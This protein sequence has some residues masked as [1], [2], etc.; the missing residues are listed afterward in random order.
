MILN[1]KSIINF[2][3]TFTN[4]K[5]STIIINEIGINQG[6]YNIKENLQVA[7]ACSCNLEIFLLF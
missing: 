7:W 6:K 5:R 4:L 3:K 2:G 1:K